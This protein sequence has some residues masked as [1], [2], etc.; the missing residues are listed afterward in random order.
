[1]VIN[2][3][4]A[5]PA[6]F[7]LFQSLIHTG[8]VKSS[9][10]PARGFMRKPGQKDSNSGREVRGGAE[11]LKTRAAKYFAPRKNKTQIQWVTKPLL[12][13]ILLDKLLI[14]R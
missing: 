5:R 13:M 6:G 3:P 11:R 7:L 4:A 1:M 2:S 9:C 14:L 8:G 12:M 10:G